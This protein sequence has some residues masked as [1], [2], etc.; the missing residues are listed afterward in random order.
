MNLSY[1]P[2]LDNFQDD[3]AVPLSSWSQQTAS[4]LRLL[5]DTLNP[6]LLMSHEVLN[7]TSGIIVANAD[8]TESLNESASLGS[9]FGLTGLLRVAGVFSGSGNHQDNTY[10]IER[11][12]T[13]KTSSHYS[14]KELFQQSAFPDALLEELEMIATFDS[15]LP[16]NANRLP[17]YRNVVAYVEDIVRHFLLRHV[18]ESVRQVVLTFAPSEQAL[19]AVSG[20]SNKMS[21]GILAQW[22]RMVE[23]AVRA[24][25]ES[26]SRYYLTKVGRLDIFK[27]QSFS[28]MLNDFCPH[29]NDVVHTRSSTRDPNEIVPIAF[30]QQYFHDWWEQ[31][32]SC[33]T[34]LTKALEGHATL[35]R[36]IATV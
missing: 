5:D 15:T 31:Q 30:G 10:A 2:I 22:C 16:D 35:R 14:G 12:E 18:P 6:A 19:E 11:V 23:Q 32:G 28:R 4:S 26:V 21:M 17:I 13:S 36:S 27:D 25:D 9:I 8:A 3:L 1:K 33:T 24:E 34:A 29:R 20:S 7:A